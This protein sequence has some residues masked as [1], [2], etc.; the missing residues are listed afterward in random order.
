L[1][2]SFKVA[3]LSKVGEV[4]VYTGAVVVAAAYNA[5]DRPEARASDEMGAAVAGGEMELDGLDEAVFLLQ[6]QYVELADEHE[7]EV[8]EFD[9]QG[10]T[11][12]EQSCSDDAARAVMSARLPGVDYQQ[13]PAWADCRRTALSDLWGSAAQPS[14]GKASRHGRRRAAAAAAAGATCTAEDAVGCAVLAAKGED[15]AELHLEVG[16]AL[17][18]ACSS[19][20]ELVQCKLE[21]QGTLKESLMV[22]EAQILHDLQALSSFSFVSPFAL[23]AMNEGRAAA[24]ARLALV[25]AELAGCNTGATFW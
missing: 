12:E 25:R 2:P 19:D 8:E 14:Q 1:A 17:D 18:L 21:E 23:A 6:L 15:E 9:R 22:E 4:G 16:C 7:A 13:R 5:G 20:E 24:E 11:W 3:V 10:D